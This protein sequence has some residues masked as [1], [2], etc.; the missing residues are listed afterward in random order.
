MKRVVIISPYKGAVEENVQ[1]AW[2]CVL[3]SLKRHEAPFASHLF[4]TVVMNDND[5]AQRSLGFA[6][7]EAWLAVADLAAVYT[8]RGLSSG[9]IKTINMLSQHLT[10]RVPIEM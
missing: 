10:I 7:E 8:D 3:D 6:C 2:Q 5:P 1:Y 9:M 4:Y